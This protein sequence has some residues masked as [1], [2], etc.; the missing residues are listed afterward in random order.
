MLANITVLSYCFMYL[1]FVIILS[2]LYFIK[3]KIYTKLS[4]NG[5]A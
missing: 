4:D 1:P 5:F 2:N 3:G